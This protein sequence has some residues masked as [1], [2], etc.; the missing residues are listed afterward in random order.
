MAATAASPLPGGGDGAAAERATSAAKKPA[1]LQC[2]T[3]Q[4]GVAHQD[5]GL[6]QDLQGEGG[7][8]S[9]AVLLGFHMHNVGGSP[10][11]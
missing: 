1:G 4:Q 5:H 8:A 9:D 2:R 7:G 11:T 10:T 3:L 6:G